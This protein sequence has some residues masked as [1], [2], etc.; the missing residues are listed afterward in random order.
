MEDPVPT[1]PTLAGLRARRAEILEAARRRGADDVRVFGSVTRGTAAADSDVDL[2]VSFAPG[3]SLFDLGGLIADLE[4]LLGRSV[5]VVTEAE[6]RA[7]VR[8]RVLADAVA[9]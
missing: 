8:E 7:R 3:R 9:L 5:D 1:G 4:A 6:L 2:L